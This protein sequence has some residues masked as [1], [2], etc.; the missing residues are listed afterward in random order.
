MPEARAFNTATVL[1]VVGV[2][3]AGRDVPIDGGPCNVAFSVATTLIYAGET[4]AISPV[5][6]AVSPGGAHGFVASGGSRSGYVWNL[7]A[8]RSGGTLSQT[9]A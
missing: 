7:V 5:S 2:L 9:R 8:N 4:L 6:I 1:P 3:V